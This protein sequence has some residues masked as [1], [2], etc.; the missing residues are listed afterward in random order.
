METAA[1]ARVAESKGVLAACVRAVTDTLD[2]GLLEPFS[3]D[4]RSGA[5]VV[6]LLRA[7]RWLG[8]YRL[9]RESSGRARAE[10]ARFVAWYMAQTGSQEPEPTGQDPSR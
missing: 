1:L 2:D 7:G 10:L 4:P 6:R 3:H 9:W 5:Q 8:R